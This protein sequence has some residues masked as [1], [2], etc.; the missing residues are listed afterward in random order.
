MIKSLCKHDTYRTID[1]IKSPKW[2]TNEILIS[3][4]KVSP[5]IDHYLVQFT[6]ES[7]KKKYGW[8]Y[9]DRETIT[10]SPTQPNGRGQVYCVSLDK[11]QDFIPL[12]QCI[13]ELK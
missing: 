2:S 9:L 12:K 7:P 3:K 1:W 5:A 6:D 4:D 13:H 11:R 10:N 8:F